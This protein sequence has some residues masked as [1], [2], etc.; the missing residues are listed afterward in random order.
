MSIGIYPK[1]Y[2]LSP[3]FLVSGR[4]HGRE[5]SIFLRHRD[6]AERMR[7]VIVGGDVTEG[8]DAIWDAEARRLGMTPLRRRA[9]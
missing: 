2:R 5:Y 4:A 7:A 3:G 6:L 1:V 8:Q 9:L